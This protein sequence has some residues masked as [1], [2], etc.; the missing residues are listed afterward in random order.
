MPRGRPRKSSSDFALKVFVA[1][2]FILLLT[3]S[4]WSPVVVT[5]VNSFLPGFSLG[6]DVPP[7]MFYMGEA[8]GS[9]LTPSGTSATSKTLPIPDY[10]KYETQTGSSAITQTI[11]GTTYVATYNKQTNA[12]DVSTTKST[13]SSS[14][15]SST[16][17]S[18][19]G[20]STTVRQTVKTPDFMVEAQSTSNTQINIPSAVADLFS[21]GSNFVISG[22]AT[23]ELLDD[24]G[25]VVYT[26][27]NTFLQG[28]TL[29]PAT[30]LY[31]QSVISKVRLK[32]SGTI[33]SKFG[34]PYSAVMRFVARK[35]L[36]GY[37]GSEYSFGSTTI[38]FSGSF[39]G[40][41]TETKSF[42]FSGEASID[43]L[44]SVL[45]GSSEN[46]ATS[47]G[48]VYM[49][50]DFQSAVAT[51]SATIKLIDFPPMSFY[52]DVHN[53]LKLDFYADA[54]QLQISAN[55]KII[56]ETTASGKQ[57]YTILSSAHPDKHT[58]Q[59]TI[60]AYYG[61]TYSVNV[62]P[63]PYHYYDPSVNSFF[64]AYAVTQ[65][66]PSSATLKAGDKATFTITITGVTKK[67]AN[68]A[69]AVYIFRVAKNTQIQSISD[70]S[71]TA[72]QP[73]DYQ[74]DVW[75]D[76]HALTD[77]SLLKD[78]YYTFVAKTPIVSSG[79]IITAK[80]ITFS[81]T[82]MFLVQNSTGTFSIKKK[83]TLTVNVTSNDFGK[84]KEF[85]FD[86]SKDGVVVSESA[87]LYALKD[88][89]VR[90]HLADKNGKPVTGL[91]GVITFDG[92]LASTGGQYLKSMD[93]AKLVG[94]E[95]IA[96]LSIRMPQN[97]SYSVTLG[98]YAEVGGVR[99]YYWKTSMKISE[100]KYDIYVT[101]DRTSDS[102]IQTVKTHVKLLS[103]QY[104]YNTQTG[105]IVVKGPFEGD[106]DLVPGTWMVVTYNAPS[107]APIDT[108]QI[109]T[110]KTTIN[111]TS[112]AS[113][114]ID[115]TSL[116]FVQNE[117]KSNVVKIT[118]GANQ[119]LIIQKVLQSTA[120]QTSDASSYDS[121][122]GSESKSSDKPLEGVIVIS[123]DFLKSV[124]VVLVVA[125]A[126][127]L[128][129]RN[130]IKKEKR[131]RRKQ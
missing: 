48:S 129:A 36:A 72:D 112:N 12:F 9:Y 91:Y 29:N 5:T 125:L 55:L 96:E 53:P 115:S 80:T 64:D 57:T 61:G 85:V 35:V 41:S 95:S 111:A 67:P 54:I 114:T 108:S 103:N 106:L 39:L 38:T 81:F 74:G 26:Q 83:V 1:S 109:Y 20:G 121:L 21:K 66:S 44:K 17:V 82:G 32:V 14:T 119:T 60:L 78:G 22:S 4:I 30:V 3:Y 23:L 73:I 94:N 100:W 130:L 113:Q 79:A 58:W 24:K 8:T 87:V 31:G 69:Q 6:I 52:Q 11:G 116:N 75:N 105:V 86:V 128:A 63:I 51:T 2:F 117:N 90:L 98:V 71:I 47:G 46:G 7:A 101:V 34:K 92:D 28:L 10:L 93:T 102:K 19:S 84:T 18:S 43:D 49:V 15:S 59:V 37:Y 118:Q 127:T 120:T 123:Y 88:Y 124:A 107:N 33:Y 126:I 131:G 97:P 104:L 62:E 40:L 50:L 45:F 76:F 42:S 77:A 70:I 13:S 68:P 122:T 27:T 99:N 25:S 16:K 110:A 89:K 65:A 56:P